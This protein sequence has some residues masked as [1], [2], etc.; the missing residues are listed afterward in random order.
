VGVTSAFPHLSR[1]IADKRKPLKSRGLCHAIFLGTDPQA[2]LF[3]GIY[4]G[5]SFSAIPAPAN[6]VN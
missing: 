6:S 4:D 3:D 2:K 5:S 1:F